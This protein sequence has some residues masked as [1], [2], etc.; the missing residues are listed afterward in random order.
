MMQSLFERTAEQIADTAHKTSRTAS[1]VADVIQDGVGAARRA[2]KQGYYAAADLVD[3]AKRRVQR[4][5]VET[6][7]A[8]FAVGI[9]AGT[10]VSWMIRR[11]RLHNKAERCEKA[12]SSCPSS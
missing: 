6:V 3:D 5:P 9:A 4:H 1:A 8:T 7:V 2:T 12:E 11:G 10:L